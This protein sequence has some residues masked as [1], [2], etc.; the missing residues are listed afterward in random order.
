MSA[1]SPPRVFYPEF[2]NRRPDPEFSAGIVEPV[3]WQGRQVEPVEWLVEGLVP[4]GAVVLFSGAT[5]LGKSMLAMQLQTCMATGVPWLGRR[6][7]RVRSWGIYTEDPANVLHA[8]QVGICR[9]YGCDMADLEDMGYYCGYGK[10]TVMADY[11]RRTDAG[12]NTWFYESNLTQIR[13][14]GAE[15]VVI[16]TVARVFNGNENARPQVT[17]FVNRLLALV[18]ETNGAVLLNAHPPKNP[19][20]AYSGSTAWPST[21]RALLEIKRP[22]G[23]DAEDE[24]APDDRRVLKPGGMNWGGGSGVIKLAWQNGV[25][26]L[27]PASEPPRYSTSNAVDKI[28]VEGR[29]MRF[30]GALMKD[31][32]VIL[33]DRTQRRSLVARALADPGMRS[34]GAASLAA[35]AEHLLAQGKLVRVTIKGAVRIRP[36]DALYPDEAQG[37][38]L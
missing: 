15:L 30:I 34:I 3:E 10:D 13:R 36:A 23:F 35:A 6:V 18:K 26:E 29:V 5:K 2:P 22:K 19:D 8:R 17:D 31:G 12:Q 24:H 16:D 32:A 27:D 28:E 7:E 9:H 20:Q 1:S 21:C 25:F 33:A 38:L 4:R 11:S 37:K 14:R